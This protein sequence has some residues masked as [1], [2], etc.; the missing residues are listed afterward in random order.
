MAFQLKFIRFKYIHLNN[1]LGKH[2][3]ISVLQK[4]IMYVDMITKS[5]V[6]CRIQY[7]L[8]ANPNTAKPIQK[9]LFIKIHD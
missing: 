7:L 2:S 4:I 8:T 9:L 1:E 6:E 3:K 5:E